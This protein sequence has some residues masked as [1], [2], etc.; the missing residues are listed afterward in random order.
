MNKRDKI[1]IILFL[2]W[3]FF[4]T[5]H[6]IVIAQTQNIHFK[7]L[8]TNDG[9][10][11]S[12]ARSIRQDKYG[13]IWIGTDDGLNRYDGYTFRVYKNNSH[14]KYSISNNNVSTIFEDSRGEL[15]FGTAQGLNLYDRKNDR[16][17]QYPKL[18]Q[19]PVLSIAEDKDKILWIG[20]TVELYSFDLKNDSVRIYTPNIITHNKANLNTGGHRAIF[21]DSRNN[22]WMGSSYGLHLYDKE[23]DSFINYYYN[24]KNPHSLNNNDVYSILED[25][26]GRLWIGTAAG[27]NLFTNAHERPSNGVFVHYQNNKNDLNSISRGTVL[28]LLDD[29]KHNLWI[30]IEDGGLDLLH[31][32]AYKKGVN[33]FVHF[34]NDPNRR[35]SLS[36]NSIQSLSQDKQGSIWVGTF[37]DGINIIN[38]GSEKFI[39]IMKEPGNINSLNNNQVNAFCE[40]NGF[41]WIGTGGGLNRYDKRNDTYKHYV[42]DPLN[43]RSIGSDAVWAI[44]KDKHGNL[45]VGTWGGGLNRFDYKTG[46][47]DHYYNN[48]KDTTTIGSNN[49]FSIFEDSRGILWI[50]TMGGGLNM[51]DRKKKIFIRYDASNSGI[52][53]NYVQAIIEAKNGDLWFAN[54]SG[55]SHFDI[56][57]KRFENFQHSMNDST[58]L[59]SNVISSIFEDSRGNL[60]MGTAEGLNL[61]NN[62]TRRFT[63]YFIENGLPDNY[64][65]SILEDNHGNLWIG[66]NKGLS[67]F[68]NAINLPVK[69]EFKNYAYG[70]GLQGDEFGRRSCIRDA[71]GM[72]YFGGSNGFNVFNPDRIIEN[73]YIPPIVITD[74][75]IFNKPVV[76]GDKGLSNEIGM[77]E[78]LVLSYKQSVFSF[79]F[80]ALNYISSSK[81]QYAY[82]MEGFDKDW[83]YVG[84]KH[85]ATYTNLDPGKYIFRVRGSNNDGIWNEEGI[86]I[87]ITI[88][89]PFWQTLWFRFVML[90]VLAGAAFWIYKWRVQVRDFI[91]E[92]RME[93]AL[94]KER[95]LLRMIIDNL[96]DGIYAKDMECRK[97]FAN[98]ADYR[99]MGL[100]S[101]AQLLGKNDYELF[102][103][104]LADKFIADDRSVIQT[105]QPVLN[106]EE[107]VIDAEGQ[108]HWLMTS[109]LPLRD[110]KGQ[111]IG[112]LGIGRDITK[113]KEAEDILQESE[114]KYRELFDEAPVGYHELDVEGRIT[115]V[116]ETELKMLG[117]AAE[118]MIGQYVWKFAADEE[119]SNQRTLA[120]LAGTI[121]PSQ[122]VA[123]VLQRKDGSEMPI[124]LEDR[125]LR[126]VDG[127]ITGI[128]TIVQDITELKRIEEALEHEHNLLRT[129]I[130]LIPDYIYVK[131]TESRF[132]LGNTALIQSL[133][134]KTME[135]IYGKTDFDFHLPEAAEEY[136]ADEQEIFHTGRP[137][138]DKE[139]LIIESSGEMKWNITTKIP[140]RDPQGKIIGL[141]GNGRNITK[142]KLAE[143]KLRR[144]EENFKRIASN[145]EDIIYSV[146]A[147]TMEYRYLS[148]AFERILG[149]AEDDIKMMGGRR[150]F[151]SKIILEE[152]YMRQDQIV[153]D[154]TSHQ[155]S[156]GADYYEAWWRC[157]DGTVKCLEDHWIPV[158]H[159][160]CLVSTDGILRD[161]TERKKADEELRQSEEN[162]QRMASH[163]DE[164]LYSI[165][166]DKKEFRYLSPVFKQ[167]FGYNLENIQQMGGL[168]EF[169]SIVTPDQVFAPLREEIDN[170]AKANSLDVSTHQ[171]TWWRCKDG[172]LKFIENRW[173]ALYEGNR[174][175]RIDGVLRDMTEQQRLEEE[176][177]TFEEKLKRRNIE[178]EQMLT[179]LQEMQGK[180]IREENLAAVS[181]LTT[182]IADEIDTPLTTLTNVLKN[183]NFDILAKNSPQLLRQVS[184]GVHQ[185]KKVI[186]QLRRISRSENT[187]GIDLI[188]S[189]NE[190]FPP[191]SEKLK[192]KITVLKK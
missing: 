6:D 85:T 191:L 185:I 142:R 64:I 146:D 42:H 143:D 108:K 69:P 49:I 138:I 165:D 183:A 73:T 180:A 171:T 63:R 134:K 34:K 20:T 103:K 107:Y 48:P 158:F 36:H 117:Y 175:V 148:P 41:L 190:T 56:I 153:G 106:R 84:T 27:L 89:P 170:P 90:A 40:D 112:L 17:I 47:F 68:I 45:W 156:G 111:I 130:D 133:G 177:R 58:S 16:F 10:S 52:L 150:L 99:N 182:G 179:D 28:S 162:F 147:K 97:T 140:L 174:L 82:K 11:H 35:T 62:N 113:L 65:K 166:E 61:F 86:S 155:R 80:A 121:P 53:S 43:K 136:F 67:K 30:G 21:I 92:R 25:K 110:Q 141:V 188:K 26:T 102:P 187:A 152:K 128:R 169:F 109:K 129:L 81:N 120:K 87:L 164:V 57:T 4:F 100:E 18:S 14:D 125:L 32:D 126:D 104:E 38:P 39:H 44:C 94:S 161:I 95:N 60:W 116:N 127:K 88:I 189:L 55:F 50:G 76:I 7:H 5:V 124:L 135:E 137:L 159:E 105:G 178:L 37:G 122:G 3:I 149:Y 83:N 173:I 19:N 71:D 168:R 154:I 31:L 74:F 181:R 72:M 24:D 167:M 131:D 91:E 51:F 145:I 46:T 192:P 23:K 77:T 2:I 59:S 54:G 75:Q 12:F 184:D 163:I 151:L 176:R 15:W 1:R 160:G 78:G 157:K 29:N 33:S 93:A 186:D 66:T 13:F 22:L 144:S 79:D 70:D 98:K 114:K 96:P 8:T 115:R 132:I 118:E 172:S 9:L 119:Q 139:G 123:R 101:E